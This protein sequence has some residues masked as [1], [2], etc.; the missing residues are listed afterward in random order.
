MGYA[1]RANPAA[2]VKAANISLWLDDVRD[3]VALG[4][5]GF[6]WVK[7]VDEAKRLLQTGRVKRASLDHD[8]G[9]C[10]I[11]LDG[12]TDAEWLQR[13]A[14]QSMPHCE[15]FGTGYDLCLWMAEQRVWPIEK[16]NVHSA[17]PVG[18]DRM[19]GVI[20]RYFQTVDEATSVDAR[21]TEVDEGTACG[22]ATE[23]SSS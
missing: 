20:D 5:V 3:P 17:N 6:T 10:D 21:P 19:R 8:L 9:A 18:R 13:N 11:C 22:S 15:H 2:R 1:A 23:G 14:F 16:P 4:L 12:L 7:T